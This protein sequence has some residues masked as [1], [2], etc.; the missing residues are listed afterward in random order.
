[1]LSVAVDH[2]IA[3]IILGYVHIDRDQAIV[4]WSL[5]DRTL[6]FARRLLSHL[7]D[8]RKAGDLHDNE[9]KVKRMQMV[10]N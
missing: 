6:D 8:N 9:C 5:A 7:I 2:I 10:K 3:R 4:P 1:M